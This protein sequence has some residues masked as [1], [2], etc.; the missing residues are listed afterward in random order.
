MRVQP[1]L[2]SDIVMV[3]DECPPYPATEAEARAVDGTR[4]CAGRAQPR[5]HSASRQPEARCSASCRAACTSACARVGSRACAAIGFDG[6]AIGGLAVGEPAD[7]TQRRCSTRSRRAAAGPAALPDGRRHA[8]GHRRR[9]C[10]RGVD[11]FD[12]VMPTRN[13]RNG[14]LFTSR[15]GRQD[16]QRART[17][18]TRGRSTRPAAA[19]PAATTRRAYLRHLDRCNEI[20][21]ARLNTIHNL[22]YY[23]EPDAP[24]PGGAS[25]GASSGRFAADFLAG[26][27]GGPSGRQPRRPR[28]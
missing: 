28:V 11:M 5:R 27:E 6:Y 9:P 26:P 7:E 8:R 1:N 14:H 19:T 10:E 22:H 21:G 4:R 2:G 25:S 24:H 3:F 17:R 13:A 18:T 20:L 23:L 15:G 12:C 16:P